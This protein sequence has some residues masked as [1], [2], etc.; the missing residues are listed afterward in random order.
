MRPS[1]EQW[2]EG[3]I[4]WYVRVD[5]VGVNVAFR[6]QLVMTYNETSTTLADL[7]ERGEL[8]H[9]LLVIVC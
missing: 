9:S 6:R 4:P 8:L 5:C 2:R 3:Y 7:P 1:G